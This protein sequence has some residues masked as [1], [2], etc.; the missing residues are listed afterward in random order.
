MG[1]AELRLR[2]WSQAGEGVQP[3]NSGLFSIGGSVLQSADERRI[4]DR[5][6][7]YRGS[8]AG[9]R[10]VDLLLSLPD[11][12]SSANGSSSRDQHPA[13]EF[14]KDNLHP[15]Y[16]R[17][18][19][20]SDLLILAAGVACKGLLLETIHQIRERAKLRVKPIV[21]EQGRA[22]RDAK[23]AQHRVAFTKGGG[24]SIGDASTGGQ[25]TLR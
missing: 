24:D 19:Q 9:S 14:C 17:K 21:L 20:L 8:A 23:S 6:G 3:C 1:L 22:A 4:E 13:G 16:F 15:R 11:M 12:C 7:D 25:Y 5:P 2:D 10:G 18:R